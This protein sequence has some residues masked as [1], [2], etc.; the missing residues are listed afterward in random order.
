MKKL[1]LIIPTTLFTLSA[2]AAGFDVTT[3][4]TQSITGGNYDYIKYDVSGTLEQTGLVNITQDGIIVGGS[5]DAK[6]DAVYHGYTGSAKHIIL[7]SSVLESGAGSL[8]GNGKD[9]SSFSF[10]GYHLSAYR[11]ANENCGVLNINDITFNYSGSYDGS[12]V[13]PNGGYL[14]AGLFNINNSVVNVNE[15]K[16]LVAR[17]NS[18]MGLTDDTDSINLTNFHVDDHIIFPYNILWVFSPFVFFHEYLYIF[19][20]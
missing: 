1:T 12:G 6:V 17:T 8:S 2:F 7:G 5:A 10:I 11:V 20:Y 9:V 4:E 15:G 13:K 19:L 14:R 3:T 16:V 18:A